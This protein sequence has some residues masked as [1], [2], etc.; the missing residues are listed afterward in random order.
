MSAFKLWVNSLGMLYAN[1]NPK[2]PKTVDMN[3]YPLAKILEEGVSAA[4]YAQ[5]PQGTG[6]NEGQRYLLE[7]F[8]RREAEGH[9]PRRRII[10]PLWM[11]AHMCL[12]NEYVGDFLST[13]LV[14]TSSARDVDK[15]GLYVSHQI[16]AT[17]GNAE[18]DTDNYGMI[19]PLSPSD[20]PS[21]DMPL[22]QFIR[23]YPRAAEALFLMDED[24]L[25]RFLP[26]VPNI[27]YDEERPAQQGANFVDSVN[28]Q[29][30]RPFLF[31]GRRDGKNRFFGVTII[32]YEPV[33]SYPAR[34]GEKNEIEVT[35]SE[36]EFLELTKAFNRA[37]AF[38]NS[39]ELDELEEALRAPLRRL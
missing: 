36:R 31:G 22:S 15:D 10:P 35:Y 2:L 23:R 32:E 37:K 9:Q 16:E 18:I 20:Y 30:M 14:T 17:D 33:T 12:E 11:L 26:R 38:G 25:G 19:I 34:I 39:E 4:L 21:E 13:D 5:E 29:G 27:K 1:I 28:I 6:F 24:Q 8:K 7:G 3:R